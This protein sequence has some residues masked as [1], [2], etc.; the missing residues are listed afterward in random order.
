MHAAESTHVRH[1][2][3]RQGP[4]RC[5]NNQSSAEIICGVTLPLLQNSKSLDVIASVMLPSTGSATSA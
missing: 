4:L 2:L 1:A 5:L 3:D